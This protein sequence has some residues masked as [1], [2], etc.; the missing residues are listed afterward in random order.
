MTLTTLHIPEYSVGKEIA[1]TE[2]AIV[3]KGTENGTGKPVALKLMNDDWPGQHEI[4]MLKHMNSHSRSGPVH[5]LRLLD[6][7]ED[8]PNLWLVLEYFD[9]TIDELLPQEVSPLTL[10][11]IA[12][13][14]AKGLV[15]MDRVDIVDDDVKPTN[16]AFKAGS[17]RVA[18]LDLGCARFRGEK[19]IGS[20]DGFVAPEVR[21]GVP[22]DSSPC[23]G[24]ARTMQFLVTGQTDLAPT[25]L[26]SDWL[27]WVGR[28]FAKLIVQCCHHNPRRRPS[29][30][31]LYNR[32]KGIV[33]E[34]KRCRRCN[35]MVFRDGQ[36][37][38]C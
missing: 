10:M 32:I 37:R 19:V 6:T 20:T 9:A 30:E 31:D 24:W 25:T 13:D 28:D 21:K 1:R 5:V 11:T 38:N 15:E 2:R 26:L 34:R 12:A 33:N 16:I 3:F 27:P 7:Y 8:H 17:G 22:S 4:K 18:H 36:C 29:V 35:A 14:S 23:Y